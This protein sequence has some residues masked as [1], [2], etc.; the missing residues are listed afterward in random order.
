M[1]S[2]FWL[3]LLLQLTF[4]N[5]VTCIT[6]FL[7]E[8]YLQVYVEKK[9]PYSTHMPEYPQQ[10]VEGLGQPLNADQ[11]AT[12]EF[13]SHHQHPQQWGEEYVPMYQP[14]ES[15]QGQQS[16]TV[17]QGTKPQLQSHYQHPQWRGEYVP[18]TDYVP[19]YQSHVLSQGLPSG[20]TDQGIT[21][22]LQGHQQHPQWRGQVPNTEYVKMFYPHNLNPQ[23]VNGFTHHQGTTD[24]A[25]FIGVP[26][27]HQ[28]PQWREQV[29][30]PAHV[31]TYHQHERDQLVME[32]T[33]L[34]MTTDPRLRS[35]G[36]SGGSTPHATHNF[37]Y[38]TN[39]SGRE[40]AS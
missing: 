6:T 32:E 35:S 15:G 9:V 19:M 28:H 12:M 18:N 3:I 20:T 31:P 34:P 29:P 5:V 1:N 10:E 13:Q 14:H 37:R 30:Y 36:T 2:T 7:F 4:N 17:D 21:P 23:D 8:F 27:H 24:Q 38:L 40:R 26:M 22:E 25:G 16:G 39:L 11:G 33:G